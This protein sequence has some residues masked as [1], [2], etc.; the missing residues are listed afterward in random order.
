MRNISIKISSFEVVICVSI[1]SVPTNWWQYPYPYDVAVLS[2][3]VE[4]LQSKNLIDS[5]EEGYRMLRNCRDP[6][7]GKITKL[8]LFN[9]MNHFLG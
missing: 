7:L 6:Y 8:K 4:Y 5:Y 1:I 2:G 3:Q 9:K